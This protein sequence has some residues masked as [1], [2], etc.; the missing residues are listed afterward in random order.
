[1]AHA[2]AREVKE[3]DEALSAAR[4][5]GQAVATAHV[6][7]HAIGA[8]IYAASA[9]R[10]ATNSIKKI[11]KEREWQYNHLLNLNKKFGTINPAKLWRGQK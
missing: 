8:A 3:S 10:D 1:M 7:A 9:V 6:P 5:A 2:A 11:N 4:S